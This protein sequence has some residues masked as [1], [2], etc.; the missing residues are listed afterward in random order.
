MNVA[1]TIVFVMAAFG[2]S[3]LMFI[4]GRM[5]QQNMYGEKND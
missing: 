1:T 3:C 2:W 5:Y 4:A